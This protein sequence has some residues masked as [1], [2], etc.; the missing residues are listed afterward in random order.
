MKYES[1]E[2]F[3]VFSSLWNAHLILI[4]FLW[5]SFFLSISA[6]TIFE[7]KGKFHSMYDKMISEMET[8][9]DK[10]KLKRHQLA[11]SQWTGLLFFFHPF[12]RWKKYRNQDKVFLLN[13]KTKKFEM[14]S[15]LKTTCVGS[16]W[17]KYHSSLQTCTMHNHLTLK[18]LTT[19][20]LVEWVQIN[21]EHKVRSTFQKLSSC[22][23]KWSL[24]R[25]LIVTKKKW[26]DI[27]LLSRNGLGYFFFVLLSSVGKNIRIKTRGFCFMKRQKSLK[28]KVS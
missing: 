1:L 14:K 23:T 9:C 20:S 15:V 24:K 7:K 22:M 19:S 6:T 2:L 16:F 21:G 12:F 25:K 13:K 18:I 5:R 3:F 10:K 17:N 11:S 26:K 28:W 8:Y 27:N 4:L